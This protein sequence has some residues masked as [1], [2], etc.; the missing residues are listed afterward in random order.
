MNL[1]NV[2]KFTSLQRQPLAIIYNKNVLENFLKFIS[3]E[4]SVRTMLYILIRALC[5]KFS[6]KNRKTTPTYFV[7]NFLR[8][9]KLYLACLSDLSIF[10]TIF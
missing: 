3:Q 10:A 5:K 9:P 7:Q 6:Q 4:Q 1:K 2:T 8:I